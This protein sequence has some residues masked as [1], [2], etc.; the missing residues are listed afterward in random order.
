MVKEK[1]TIYIEGTPYESN[2]V[3][4]KNFDENSGSFKFLHK[5]L[6]RKYHGH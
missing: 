3:F 5:R 4:L 2:I 6:S 1:H